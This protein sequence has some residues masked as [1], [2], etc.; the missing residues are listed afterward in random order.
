MQYDLGYFDHE[1]YRLEPIEN[2]LGAK[3]LPMSPVRTFGIMASLVSVGVQVRCLVLGYLENLSYS[4]SGSGRQINLLQ[5]RVVAFVVSCRA[6][7]CRILRN[8]SM[9][10]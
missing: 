2:P 1:A 10:D 3:V 8:I 4:D 7:A 9:R 6:Y 5:V